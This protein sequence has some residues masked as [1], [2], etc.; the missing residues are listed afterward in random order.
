[1]IP[2]GPSTDAW[3]CGSWGVVVVSNRPGRVRRIQDPVYGQ[4]QVVRAIYSIWPPSRDSGCRDTVSSP[5]HFAARETTSVLGNQP[6]VLRVS[7]TTADCCLPAHQIELVLGI[8]AARMYTI[9]TS[10]KEQRPRL[11]VQHVE[12]QITLDARK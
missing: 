4:V 7:I 6:S 5:T 3:R 11:G 12:H 8:Q 9:D 10:G 2:D 1:M